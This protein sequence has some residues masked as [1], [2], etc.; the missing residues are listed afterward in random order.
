MQAPRPPLFVPDESQLSDPTTL[1]RHLLEASAYARGSVDGVGFARLLEAAAQ[2]VQQQSSEAKV[3][4]GLAIA[5]QTLA[6]ELA[7]KCEGLQGGY[8]PAADPT[9]QP[10]HAPPHL[11]MASG[12]PAVA[13]RSCLHSPPSQQ[14]ALKA[15]HGYGMPPSHAPPAPMPAAAAVPQGFGPPPGGIGLA[16][17]LSGVVGITQGLYPVANANAAEAAA[18][19]VSASH[20]GL[21][22]TWAQAEQQPEPWGASAGVSSRQPGATMSASG[23][24]VDAE[25]ERSVDAMVFNLKQRFKQSGVTLPL[26]KQSGAVYRLGS[27]KLQV[28]RRCTPH[29]TPRPPLAL[30]RSISHACVRAVLVQL[31]IRNSRLTVRVGG[32]FI[33]FLE[34]LSK[35]AL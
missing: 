26:E 5:S 15:P 18:E 31:S 29:A 35:A 32:N 24:A 2:A 25:A 20:G 27:R 28:N 4:R 16:A 3:Q 23:S 14:T 21:A 19:A 34:Y 1:M 8:Q 22:K 9:Q 17:G 11:L 10:P 6:A 7:L 33:D 30:H 13:P 12:T